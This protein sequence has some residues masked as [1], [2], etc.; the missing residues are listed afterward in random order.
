MNLKTFA[1][2]PLAFFDALII[3][4]AAGTMPFSECMAEHQREWFESI[5]PSL[6]AVANGEKPPCG[7]YWVERTKGGSKDS[8]TALCLLYLLAFSRVRLDMQVGAADRDQAAELKK[9]ATDVLRLNAW[10]AKRIEATA[11]Q[12]SCK[13]TGSTCDILASDVAGSHG[14]RPDI[15]VMNELSHVT[16]EDFAANLLDNATKKPN[17]IVIVATNAGFTGTWQ[18][19]WRDTAIESDRWNVQLYSQPA[20]WLSDD[21]VEEAKRRN[22]RA[23]FDRLFWGIWASSAGDALDPEDLKAAVDPAAKPMKLLSVRGRHQFVIS[24]L[25]LGIRH[26]HAAHVGVLCDRNTLQLRL[27]FA[28][29]W[30]PNPATGKINLMDVERSILDANKRFGIVKV[31]YDPYQAALLSQRLEL[32]DVTMEEMTF[33]GKNLNLM[34]STLLEVFRSR[35]ITLYNHPQL[36][37]DLGRLTIEEKSYGFRL[38]ATRDA[39]GHADLA[40]ALAIALPAA[41]EL[42]GTVPIIAGAIPID[43]PYE[44]G[45]DFQKHLQKEQKRTAALKRHYDYL[46]EGGDD[47]DGQEDWKRYMGLL[48]RR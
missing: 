12:L 34:A 9:A 22:S 3:P 47:R 26:D 48:G 41:V 7:R 27:A 35:R 37:N 38:S 30:A 24:G 23:R 8:D 1:T 39:S 15:V 28:E 19:Q 42:V 36:V 14:A 18:Q 5:A 33:V 4:S 6:V 16:K 11:W 10:L 40:T 44:T 29:S 2:D 45:N 32:Q 13:A 46:Q 20:P 17:G 31:V 21:E 43:R 25:D